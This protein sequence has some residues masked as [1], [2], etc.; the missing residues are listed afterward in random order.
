[1]IYVYLIRSKNNRARTYIGITKNLRRRLLEHNNDHTTSTSAGSPWELELYLAFRSTEKAS[2]F[3]RY[4]KHG[5]GY[6]FA[7]RHFW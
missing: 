1:M 3:E 7:Q 2:H 6:A 4:L 5:S